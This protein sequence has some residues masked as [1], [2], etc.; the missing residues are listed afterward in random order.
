MRESQLTYNPLI[1]EFSYTDMH[2]K[3]LFVILIAA[4]N[5]VF[6]QVTVNQLRAWTYEMS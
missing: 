5:K 3:L 4:G 1:G 2:V 6:Q